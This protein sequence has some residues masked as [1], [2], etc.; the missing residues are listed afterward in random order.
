M[1]IKISL[2]L[3]VCVLINLQLFSQTMKQYKDSE[4]QI[5]Y[6]ASWQI[7]EYPNVAF[8]FIRPLEEKG[9][10]FR[11]N[12]N[13]IISDSKGLNLEAYT[14]IN[15]KQLQAQ[16]INYKHISTS[17]KIIDNKTFKE[18]IY[19]HTSNDLQL[20]VVYYYVIINNKVYEFTFSTLQSSYENY[21]P[22]FT[23]IIS[24]LRFN[25]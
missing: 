5:S 3:L 25:K 15:K 6:P 21:Y 10:K 20:Q 19:K 11:E 17:N 16:L 23:K 2:L 4:L 8:L 7:I 9:Q 1:K 13:L 14:A 18:I 12:V 22:V 24:S